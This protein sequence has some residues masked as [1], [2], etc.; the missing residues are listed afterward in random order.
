[1]IALPERIS[2]LAALGTRLQGLLSDNDALDTL[3]AQAYLANNWFTP[4]NIRLALTE[5]AAQLTA[6]TLKVWTAS[7]ELKPVGSLRIGLILAGNLPLVGWADV[8]A[9]LVSGHTALVKLSSQDEVLMKALFSYL[10]EIAPGLA[11]QIEV[12]DRLENPD[13][14][15]ATGGNNSARYFNAYFGKYPHIIRHNR[16]SLAVLNGTETE[17]QLAGLG[18]DVFTYFGLGCRSVSCLLIPDDYEVGRLAKAWMPFADVVNHHKY[19][20]NI[21]Y[22]RAIFLMN[23]DKFYDMGVVLLR[24]DDRLYS[25]LAVINLVRYKS[26][27]EAQAWIEARQADIQV[28]VGDATIWP[29]AQPVGTAQHPGLTDYADGVDTLAWLDSLT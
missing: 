6:D 9:V 5:T 25:P 1:M 20:N 29:G 28:V 19:A 3:A 27:A 26:I 24:A 7:Y 8:L 17:E 2:A 10:R 18:A 21:D 4:D 13:T 14:V 15:I 22:H 16:N 12:I 23:L 11:G